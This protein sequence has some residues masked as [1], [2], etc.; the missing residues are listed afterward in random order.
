[1]LTETTKL[2]LNDDHTVTAVVETPF[3]TR[4]RNGNTKVYADGKLRA[5]TRSFASLS[6]AFCYYGA[7]RE[8]EEYLR[9]CSAPYLNRVVWTNVTYDRLMQ[10]VS[11]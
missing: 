10:A 5:R 3:F 9:S 2:T 4:G 7:A 1:M 11:A 8:T 6:R